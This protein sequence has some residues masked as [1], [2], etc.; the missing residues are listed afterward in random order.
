MYC[1]VLRNSYVYI[2]IWSKLLN[3]LSDFK[4]LC[5]YVV[6]ERFA[7]LQRKHNL[8]KI[9]NEGDIAFE[10]IDYAIS[11]KLVVRF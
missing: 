2:E 6:R 7:I 8:D 11:R 10:S 1:T 3:G 4:N 9:E 5:M